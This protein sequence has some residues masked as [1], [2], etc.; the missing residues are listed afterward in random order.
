ML[1]CLI[2]TKPPFSQFNACV[3]SYFWPQIHVVGKPF[4]S[5][6]YLKNIAYLN[7]ALFKEK[8]YCSS[9]MALSQDNAPVC[10]A[11]S[12]AFFV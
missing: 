11:S 5:F 12:I 10:L 6:P 7:S 4:N 1:L 9:G 8:P 2:V 3:V